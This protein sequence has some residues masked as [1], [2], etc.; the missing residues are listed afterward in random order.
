MAIFKV[1]LDDFYEIVEKMEA[2]T[3]F[4]FEY[5]RGEIFPVQGGEPLPK[6]YLESI[7]Y[8]DFP[9]HLTEIETPMATKRHDKIIANLQ[10]FLSFRTMDSDIVL[11]SQGTY[12]YIELKG[13]VRIPDLAAAKESTEK[14][15]KKHQLL[16]PRTLF[17]IFSKSTQKIDETEKLEEYKSIASVEEYVMIAQDTPHVSVHRRVNNTDWGQENLNNLSDTLYLQSMETSISLSEI[18]KNINWEEQE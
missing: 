9:H 13:T 4:R 7:L 17:E 2:T 12:V 1:S 11:Y 15:N 8:K 10:R 5:V 6:H 16:N 14:R 18:Y 3:H